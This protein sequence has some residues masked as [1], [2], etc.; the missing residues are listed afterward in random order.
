VGAAGATGA[1]GPKGDTGARG[2]S[3]AYSTTIPPLSSPA[4]SGNFTVGTL[5]NLPAGSYVLLAKANINNNH[6]AD[7]FVTCQLVAGGDVD[8]TYIGTRDGTQSVILDKQ[9]VGMNLT[10]TFASTGTVT[11]QC[12]NPGGGASGIAVENTRITAIRVESLG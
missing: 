9:Q 11:L 10:H 3:N 7:T 1:Q 4:G 12:D 8:E 6:A 5:S 2:P